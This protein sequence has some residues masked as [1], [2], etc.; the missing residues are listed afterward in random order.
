[1]SKYFVGYGED[2]ETA[3]YEA[4]KAFAEENGMVVSTSE[5]SDPEF[6]DDDGVPILD[7]GSHG[8]ANFSSTELMMEAAGAEYGAHGAGGWMLF[9]FTGSVERE[10]GQWKAV[11]GD[12]ELVS[13]DDEEERFVEGSTR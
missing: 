8:R 2:P 13:L 11:A 9:S 12:F 1:M 7:M 4:A 3:V 5:S 10:G 6:F